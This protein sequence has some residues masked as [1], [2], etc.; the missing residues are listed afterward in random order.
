MVSH[1]LEELSFEDTLD[2]L[3]TRLAEMKLR[4]DQNKAAFSDEESAELHKLNEGATE[5]LLEMK[6]SKMAGEQDNLLTEMLAVVDQIGER[7]SAV[8]P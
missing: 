5:K 6:A 3:E 8:L 2:I 7:V 1:E 4:L